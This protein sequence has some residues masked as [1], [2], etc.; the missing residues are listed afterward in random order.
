MAKSPL[1]IVKE[2]FGDKES[3]SPPSR[4]SPARPLGLAHEQGQGARARL[5]REA[6]SPPRDVHRREGEVRDAREAHRGDPRGREARE[7]RGLQ[8]STSPRSRSPACGTC[9]SRASKRNAGGEGR[10]RRR[11]PPRREGR[12]QKP[13]KPAA[14]RRRR[15]EGVRVSLTTRAL[16]LYSRARVSRRGSP[17]PLRLR[18]TRH[19]DAKEGDG[20]DRSE[21]AR[22]RSVENG[23]PAM[24][25]MFV[26]KAI[27]FTN[28]V[29][30]HK[31]RLSSFE[32][33]APR[34]GDREGEP[35]HGELDLPPA[36]QGAQPEGGREAHHAGPDRPLR[37][38][39]PGHERAEPPHR[40][41][42]RPRP[43]G[44]PEAL[45]LPLR[46]PQ[47]RR[48]GE[49]GGRLRRGPRRDD[50]RDDARH[51]RSTRRR[52]GTSAS[53]SSRWRRRC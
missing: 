15:Q 38:G 34:R 20:Q 4:S 3:S 19:L 6:P 11:R 30:V 1:A 44:G 10:G 42:D 35:R 32:L 40:G 21:A 39:P 23:Y 25:E 43:P 12:R 29:G 51:R 52:R 24:H 2:K 45:R 41:V 28:G 14:S 13:A 50:A 16:A 33:V 8:D 22:S 9:T 5:E 27:F 53:R 48:D 36:L 47:L 31:D 46:A 17:A 7:G 49:E 26:P 18:S 37:H